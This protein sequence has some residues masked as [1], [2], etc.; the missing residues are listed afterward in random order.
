[1]KY[2][3]YHHKTHDGAIGSDFKTLES[4]LISGN[5]CISGR[6][7]IKVETNLDINRSKRR[8]NSAHKAEKNAKK[9]IYLHVRKQVGK[10]NVA[11]GNCAPISCINPGA[12]ALRL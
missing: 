12:S 10:W 9:V 5:G 3:I 7:I 6:G 4:S 8:V 11:K 2:C 1:M